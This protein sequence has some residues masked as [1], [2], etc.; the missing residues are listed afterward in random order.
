M[1]CHQLDIAQGFLC[2]LSVQTPP[3]IELLASADNGYDRQNI[4]H[5]IAPVF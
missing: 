2:N 3:A 5:L 4:N 1:V